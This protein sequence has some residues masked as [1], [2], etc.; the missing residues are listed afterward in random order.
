MKVKTGDTVQIISG[1][2]AG[3]TGRILHVFP[4]DERVV[5]EGA[6]IVKRHK[7]AIRSG[8]ESGIVE[9]P[10]PLHVSNVKV[11]CSKCKLPTRIGYNGTGKDKKR[12]CKK[13]YKTLD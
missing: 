10:A 1:K 8:Q 5:V 11:V 13:C 6:N 7:K 4:H 2:Q 12:V 9:K 3:V